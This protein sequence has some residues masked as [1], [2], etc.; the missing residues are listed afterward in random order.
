[1]SRLSIRAG[2]HDINDATKMTKVAR[3]ESK[4][5]GKNPRTRKLASKHE[6]ILPEKYHRY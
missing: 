1:L 3:W 4:S 2:S 5:L 6:T